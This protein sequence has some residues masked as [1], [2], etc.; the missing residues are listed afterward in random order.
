[1]PAPGIDEATRQALE[2]AFVE[3]GLTL[4][5]IAGKVGVHPQTAKKVRMEL[6]Q[7]GVEK[8]RADR[9][10]EDPAMRRAM[11]RDAEFW[12]R[13]AR[14]FERIAADHEQLARELAGIS[15]DII[16]I[17]QWAMRDPGRVGKSVILGLVTD[18][19]M[20]EVI[21]PDEIQGINAFNPDVAYERMRRYFKAAVH[22]G[23]RWSSDTECQGFMLVLGGDLIS[24][25]IHDELKETNALTSHEQVDAASACIAAGVDALLEAYPNIH[26]VS[27]PGNHG[28]NTRKPT[29]KLAARTSYDMV[30]AKRLRDHFSDDPRVS[31]QFGRSVDQTVPVFGRSVFVTHGDRI[32]TRGGMGFAGPMLPI[33]R[34]TK[35]ILE[36]QASVDRTPDL[37]VH[38]HYH[39]TGNPGNV[40]SNGSVPG[41]GEFANGLRAVVEPPQQWLALLHDRW[42]LRDRAPIKLEDPEMPAKPRVRVPW[43]QAA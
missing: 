29:A 39:T 10:Q 8:A 26:I 38:G 4:S 16:D 23:T 41:Y 19:H 40:L 7:A 20:G 33:V 36:Q 9:E 28:R 31:H 5:K 22:V 37:I 35:K 11:R 42:W 2:N 13:E 15:G 6:L 1:M 30:V 14:R 25:D 3:G 24:G 12:R 17:P 32:G 18:L 43:G 27:V 21:D 34:G